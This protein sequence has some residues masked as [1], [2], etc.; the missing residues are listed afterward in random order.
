MRFKNREHAGKLL[1]KELDKYANDPSVIVLALPRGGVPVG[2]FIA[3]ALHVELDILIVRK[4]G[5]PGRREVAMGAISSNDS[6]ILSQDIISAY[7][8]SDKEIE[9]VS[10][11]EF[12]ELQRRER[13][14]RGNKP[15]FQL[16]DRKVILVDDGLATGATMLAALQTVRQQ[17]PASIIIAVPV[18][19]PDACS[20]LRSKVDSVVCVEMPEWFNAVGQWYDDFRQTNDQEVMQLLRRAWHIDVEPVMN[21]SGNA[22]AMHIVPRKTH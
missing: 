20:M 19:A 9:A 17:N 10:K 5:L 16:K 21:L 22:K 7:D 15:S 1:A 11:E 4:L 6:R 18:G 13:V 12:Q 8:I 2:F 3:E 14:Y